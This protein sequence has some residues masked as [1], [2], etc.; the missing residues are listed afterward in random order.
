MIRDALHYA[1]PETM[2]SDIIRDSSQEDSG[3]IQPDDPDSTDSTFLRYGY[4]YRE[5]FDDERRK[6]KITMEET[7][8]RELS[9]EEMDKVSGGIH[10]REENRRAFFVFFL[11]ILQRG[12]QLL[13]RSHAAHQGFPPGA[14]KLSKHTGT[15][16]RY[17]F[18]MN[19]RVLLP[20][21]FLNACYKSCCSK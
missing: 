16:L 1:F 3:Q 14:I 7:A 21:M 17:L 12:F 2:I 6:E 18:Y 11:S 20:L 5:P 19:R 4:P 8:M 9:L 13:S 10:G 15:F